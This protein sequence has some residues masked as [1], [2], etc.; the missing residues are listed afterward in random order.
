MIRLSPLYPYAF[1]SL[2]GYICRACDDR[3]E[4][5]HVQ[6]T[7]TLAYR[8]CLINFVISEAASKKAPTPKSAVVSGPTF[9]C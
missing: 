4:G 7:I 6:K 3:Q 1:L 2:C 5:T 8:G 9:L